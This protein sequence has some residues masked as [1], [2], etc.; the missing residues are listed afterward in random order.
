MKTSDQ[1][2]DIRDIVLDKYTL[3]I[4]TAAYI[5]RYWRL[6]EMLHRRMN[7][8]T[9]MEN[10]LIHHAGVPQEDITLNR[11]QAHTLNWIDQMIEEFEAKGD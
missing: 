5:R 4:I 8:Y 10:W 6:M 2:R 9:T 7:N 1:L 3:S 11:V